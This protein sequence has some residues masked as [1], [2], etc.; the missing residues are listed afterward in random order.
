MMT[1]QVCSP[2]SSLA[3]DCFFVVWVLLSIAV[4]SAFTLVAAVVTQISLGKVVRVYPRTL[5]GLT[6]YHA[7]YIYDLNTCLC[8]KCKVFI[9]KS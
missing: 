9:V 2:Y 3:M 7:K 4:A 5:Q 1:F 6:F 8:Y